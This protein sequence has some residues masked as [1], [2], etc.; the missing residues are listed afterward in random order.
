MVTV[1]YCMQSLFSLENIE[2]VQIHCQTQW[3]STRLKYC[4]LFSLGWGEGTQIKRL[5]LWD[6]LWINGLFRWFESW[7][8]LNMSNYLER[9][10]LYNIFWWKSLYVVY[11]QIIHF[12]EQMLGKNPHNIIAVYLLATVSLLTEPVK[13]SKV[14]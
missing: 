2:T 5:V 1:A 6:E 8:Q 10:I 3:K 12:E 7:L 13:Y 11:W 4:A 9:N 14:N